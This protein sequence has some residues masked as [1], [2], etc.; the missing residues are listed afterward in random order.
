VAITDHDLPPVIP[1]GRNLVGKKVIH[2]IHGV[3]LSGSHEGR[4]LHLLVYFPGEMP[5]DFRSFCQGRAMARAKR[6]DRA[7]LLLEISGIPPADEAA[8]R[9]ERSLTRLHLAQAM[10]EA[11]VA[12][13][14]QDAFTRWLSQNP[15]LF[16]P[17]ELTFI[18]AIQLA[19]KAGGI[20]SWAHPSWGYAQR[21]TSVFAEAGLQGLEALRPSV[22][23]KARKRFEKLAQEHGLFLTGG[24]DWHGWRRGN[25]GDFA[26]NGDQAAPFMNALHAAS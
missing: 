24:S 16:P 9:G 17:V 10:V 8:K 20:C 11:G 7:R 3:E 26:V 12:K 1:S 6:Y 23:K 2:V 21:W 15:K 19:R 4:E 25:V 22:K 5:A 14:N 18:Q 13:D